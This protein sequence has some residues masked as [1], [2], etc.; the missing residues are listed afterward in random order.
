MSIWGSVHSAGEMTAASEHELFH[1]GPVDDDF[2][3]DVAVAWGEHPIRLGWW[4]TDWTPDNLLSRQPCEVFLT[5]AMA[6]R[7][8]QTLCEVAKQ[9]M[10]PTERSGT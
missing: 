1:D 2:T 10:P 6:Y 8:G 7:L 4:R 3:V 5:P 9:H